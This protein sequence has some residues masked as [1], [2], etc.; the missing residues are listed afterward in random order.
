MILMRKIF[1]SAAIIMSLTSVLSCTNAP[2]SD[3]ES[4]GLLGKVKSVTSVSYDAFDKFGEGNLQKAKPRYAVIYV[5]SYD[6]LGNIAID[7]CFCMDEVKREYTTIKNDKNQDVKWIC[8][9]DDDDTKMQYG[10]NY[11]YDEKGNI[12]KELDL[13]DGDVDIFKNTY[14][15]EGKLVSQISGSYK[16][17]WYYENGELVKFTENFLDVTESEVFYKNGK[18]YK[19]VRGSDAY[20]LYKYDDYDRI[21]EST[22][23]KNDNINKKS[24]Q[25]FNGINGKAPIERI[26]WNADGEIEHDYLYTYFTVGNDTVTKITYDND[27]IKEIEFYLKSAKDLTEETYT[28]S[29]YLLYGNQFLYENGNLVSM[30]DIKKGIEYKYNND[31]LTITEE[32]DDKLEEIKYRRNNRISRIVKDKNGKITY[33]YIE[34]GSD[35][36]ITITIIEDGE[37]KKGER[38]YENGKLVK[39]TDP[40]N[41]LTTTIS[42]ND[43]GFVSEK[44]SSDG[45]VLTYKYEY[46]SMGN[47]VK[48]VEYENGKAK[49]ITE[50]AIVYYDE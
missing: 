16:R 13:K 33:S 10:H 43:K 22:M 42:Y 25:F 9:E 7:K 38:I 2:K 48:S 44:K 18:I 41:G 17:H 24:K 3:L 4:D 14:N 27:I 39:Y 19:D 46:D 8:Y 12:I 34:D 6:S 50:R 20:W 23:Y 47:W 32:D 31:I 45:T 21:V 37:T 29:S 15:D 30:R 5:T 49:Q 40:S 11:Y 1:N 36:K 26:E 28:T 35:S